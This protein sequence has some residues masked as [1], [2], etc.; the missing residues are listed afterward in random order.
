[1]SAKGGEHGAPHKRFWSALSCP[2]FPLSVALGE[3]HFDAGNS[4]DAFASGDLQE[5]GFVWAI[6]QVHH[7]PAIQFAGRKRGNAIV[8]MH[9]DWGSVQNGVEGLRAQSSAGNY[10]CAKSARKLL[11]DFFRGARR[12][13]RLR[14]RALAQK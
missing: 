8:R 13:R 1:L 7:E 6:D 5:L 2:E 11:C 14:Q 4:G 10:L 12:W 9:A 3:K